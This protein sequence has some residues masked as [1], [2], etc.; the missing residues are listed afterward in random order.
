VTIFQFVNESNLGWKN[1]K[2]E[3]CLGD[4]KNLTQAS[5]DEF[6]FFQESQQETLNSPFYLPPFGCLKVYRNY[7]EKKANKE[8]HVMLRLNFFRFFISQS[9]FYTIYVFFFETR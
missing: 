9:V 3:E 4:I 6:I 7:N 8:T 2:S 1:V 5:F